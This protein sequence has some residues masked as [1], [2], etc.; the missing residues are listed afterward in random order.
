M[1]RARAR[2]R[3]LGW[4]RESHSL[5]AVGLLPPATSTVIVCIELPAWETVLDARATSCLGVLNG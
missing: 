3:T 4:C 2:L 1:R 5:H